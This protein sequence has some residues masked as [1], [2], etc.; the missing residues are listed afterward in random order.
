LSSISKHQAEQRLRDQI[1]E[2]EIDRDYPAFAK[3][4]KAE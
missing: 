4:R 2:D 3:F 1:A